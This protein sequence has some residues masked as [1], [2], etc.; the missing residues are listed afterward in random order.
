MAVKMETDSLPFLKHSHNILIYW[1][2]TEW[3]CPLIIIYLDPQL[4]HPSFS[5]DQEVVQILTYVN[6]YI[7]TETHKLSIDPVKLPV[8]FPATVRQYAGEQL[9]K[10]VVVWSLKEIQPAHIVQVLAQLICSQ[11]LSM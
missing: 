2:V 6:K 3:Q 11:T 10:I 8:T 9:T 7:T 1:T 4:V 5:T